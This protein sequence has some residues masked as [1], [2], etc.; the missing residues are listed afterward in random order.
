MKYLFSFLTIGLLISF[1]TPALASTTVTKLSPNYSLVTLS[2]S[3]NFINRDVVAPI[4]AS[5]KVRSF[6]PLTAKY[7]LDM[8]DTTVVTN[9]IILSPS[10]I[11]KLGYSTLA[12]Q[13]QDYLL[14][15]IVKHASDFDS[16][17]LDPKLKELPVF[18]TEDDKVIGQSLKTY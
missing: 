7:D 18:F 3:E 6:S 14:V 5:H 16:R 2:F 12:G 17:K 10:P 11:N 15:L 13:K 9:S 1:A 8:S 4:L